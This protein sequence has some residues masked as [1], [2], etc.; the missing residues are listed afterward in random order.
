MHGD[1]LDGADN[2]NLFV[3]TA[4]SSDEDPQ[5]D[6]VLTIA[7]RKTAPA[8]AGTPSPSASQNPTSA[9]SLPAKTP[10]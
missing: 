3:F 2:A 8:F 5:A 10:Q 4:D 9:S 6:L 1:P 7:V